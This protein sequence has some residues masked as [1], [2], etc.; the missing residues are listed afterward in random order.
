VVTL[1]YFALALYFASR[2]YRQLRGMRSIAH[3]SLDYGELVRRG[4]AKKGHTF[5]D[6]RRS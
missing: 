6:N 5:E 3:E 2:M 4:P 1:L